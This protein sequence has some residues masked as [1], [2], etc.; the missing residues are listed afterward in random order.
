VIG[1]VW[2]HEPD[3]S[4][5]ALESAARLQ[6]LVEALPGHT[7]LTRSGDGYRLTV[8]EN[9][10]DYCQAKSLYEEAEHEPPLRRAETLR[11]AFTLWPETFQS[12]VAWSREV[13]ALMRRIVDDM[14]ATVKAISRSSILPDLPDPPV[15]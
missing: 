4:A 1:S 10:V 13:D 11:A 14:D 5:S 6:T 12:D 15:S 2:D 9:L 7:R 3:L 8:D